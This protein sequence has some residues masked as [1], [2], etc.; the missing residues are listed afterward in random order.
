[1]LSGNCFTYLESSEAYKYFMDKVGFDFYKKVE[2]LAGKL[3]HTYDKVFIM[4]FSVGATIAW[5]YGSVFR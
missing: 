5:I 1:M 2:E 4:G 3:K